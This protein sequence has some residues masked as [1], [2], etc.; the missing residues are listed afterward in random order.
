MAQ[1][2]GIVLLLLTVAG[3]AGRPSPAAPEP[4]ATSRPDAPP[5][6]S[7]LLQAPEHVS[8][9]EPVVPLTFVLHNAGAG[10]VRV[11]A[12]HT[13]LEGIL[14]D[15]FEVTVA[16]RRLDYR[17]PMVKRGPP[18][19]AEFVT[20]APGDHVRATVDLL[21]GY[22]LSRAG[23]YTVRFISADEYACNPLRITR[24]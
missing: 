22:D 9:A 1:R 5:L 11:L 14:G 16:G 19:A 7:C 18:D 15:L 17:G 10:E 3:C 20:L 6:V 13:P 24:D 21:D 23:Q 4:V 2:S 8:L 12:R